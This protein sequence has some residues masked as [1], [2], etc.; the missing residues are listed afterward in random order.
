MKKENFELFE[1]S[2]VAQQNYKPDS[3]WIKV[4]LAKVLVKMIDPLS[5]E[6]IEKIIEGDHNVTPEASIVDCWTPLETAYFTRQNKYH[7]LNGNIVPF[8]K[9]VEAVKLESPN[10]ITDE[11]IVEILEKK[12]MAVR[13]LL[14]KLD[15]TTAVARVLRLAEDL[16]KPVATINAI[17]EKLA[18]LQQKE[19]EG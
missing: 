7:I 17:K 11:E 12:F 5:G 19:Y 8:S 6:A 2:Q 18:T 4:Q 3:R 10:T 9:P 16:N 14:A 1:A 15:S 13:S